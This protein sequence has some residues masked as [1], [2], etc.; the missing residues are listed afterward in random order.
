MNVTKEELDKI[1]NEYHGNDVMQD[2]FIEDEC[3]FYTYSWVFDQLPKDARI[4]ELGYGEGNFTEELVTRGYF[5]TV[6]DGSKILLDKAKEMYGDKIEIV[7][8]LFEE[9]NPYEKFDFILATHVLEHVDEPISLLKEMKKWLAPNG[10]IIIIVPNKESIHRQLAVMMGM[11]PALDTL[12]ER[13]HLV[14][15]QRVY[16]LDTLAAD[17]LSADLKVGE[18]MGFFLK[19][20]PNSMMLNYSLDLVK[21]LNN[22]SPMLPPNLLANIALVAEL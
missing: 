22:I 12:G 17:V 21:A 11:M 2:K 10:K 14:G 18:K 7:H 3:Q 15:H 6:I 16:S 4:I 9:Y 20:M 8:S 19:T 13:D 5:P 1:A